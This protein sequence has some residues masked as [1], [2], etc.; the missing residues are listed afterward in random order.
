MK[1]Y[2]IW[3]NH[4][5][6]WLIYEVTECGQHYCLIKTFKTKKGAE[7]WAKKTWYT[8]NWR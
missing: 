6:A 8:V 4:D 1:Y 3:Q 7:G 2:E 5:G